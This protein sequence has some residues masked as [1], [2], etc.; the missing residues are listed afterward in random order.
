M[1]KNELRKQWVEALR[2][3]EY[4]QGYGTLRNVNNEYCCLGV[5]CDIVAKDQPEK[6][7]WKHEMKGD[8]FLVFYERGNPFDTGRAVPIPAVMTM[9]GLISSNGTLSCGDTLTAMNDDG[10]SFEELARFIE[11]GE[12][13]VDEQPVR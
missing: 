4:R 2:S 8:G 7:G 6:F 3:G 11:A 12:A 5:L 10:M 1:T 9:A 13:F